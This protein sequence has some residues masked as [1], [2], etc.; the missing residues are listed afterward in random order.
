MK[1]RRLPFLGKLILL[2]GNDKFG[3]KCDHFLGCKFWFVVLF[4]SR[5]SFC[6]VS[7]N[8]PKSY[9]MGLSPPPPTESVHRNLTFFVMASPR[10][11]SHTF[12]QVKNGAKDT[13][14][15]SITTFMF[16]VWISISARDLVPTL[17]ILLWLLWLNKHTQG[18]TANILE[19]QFFINQECSV[20]L[21]DIFG[22]LIL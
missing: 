11:E 1:A 20:R 6:E 5:I 14:I 18:Q 4:S 13:V 16:Y 7:K 17:V 2:R 8:N 19:V 15:R 21:L 3:C 12:L 9:G 10:P 22:M